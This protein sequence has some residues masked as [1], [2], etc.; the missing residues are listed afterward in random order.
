MSDERL[1]TQRRLLRAAWWEHAIKASG[2]IEVCH[3]MLSGGAAKRCTHPVRKSRGKA[4]S[5]PAPQF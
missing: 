3:Q 2:E 5:N 1:T 4:G